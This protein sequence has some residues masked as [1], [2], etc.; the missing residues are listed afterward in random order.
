MLFFLC[1]APA[2]YAESESESEARGWLD[3]MAAALHEQD[4]QGIFTYV[5][6][7]EFN[8][9]QIVHKFKDGEERERLLQLN[10]EKLEI[11]RVDNDV[12]CRHENSDHVDLE[13]HVPIGPFSST[14]SETLVAY[15]DFYGVKLH[16]EG[17]IA[18][19]PAMKLAISPRNNDRYGYLLWL[20][21]E[22][23]LLLQSH[24]IDVDRKRVREIFQFASIEIG[25]K[26]S[27]ANLDSSMAEDAIAHRLS[28]EVV[29]YSD[30][31][32]PKPRWRV[33]WLPNGFKP[34]PVQ[35]SG[36]FHFTD[37]LATFSV[38]VEQAGGSALPDSATQVGG[39]VVITRRLK[40]RNGQIT[41]VGEVPFSIAERVAESVEPVIY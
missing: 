31:A 40:Q 24:M 26:I 6:G 36:R 34:V 39:T 14:F 28:G 29:V 8:T 10:D 30:D 33:A 4:Y 1:T 16:G 3:K 25:P 11:L 38:F 17:R 27:M 5:R 7:G 37:G 19:R 23:G 15:K 9:M 21:K 41:V 20:D 2:V 32:R 12:V 35:G 13:H 18:G 22:T